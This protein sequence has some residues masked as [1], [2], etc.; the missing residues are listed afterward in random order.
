MPNFAAVG[1][2]DIEP[3][4][5]TDDLSV[6]NQGNSYDTTVHIQQRNLEIPIPPFSRIRF[7]LILP[8]AGTGGASSDPWGRKP[9][10]TMIPTMT[11]S[12]LERLKD[13]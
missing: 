4:L 2:A 3:T 11:L 8:D 1:S 10:Q 6:A 13:E 5:N 12:I 9:W 7:S